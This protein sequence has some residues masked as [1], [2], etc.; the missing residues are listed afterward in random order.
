MIPPASRQTGFA[1]VSSIF[2]IVV[3]AALGVVMVTL[4][5][6]E[7]G[8]MTQSLTATRV[9]YGAKAGLEWGIHRAIA[10]NATCL[11]STSFPLTGPGFSGVSVT[12][13]CSSPRAGV[14]HI[15]SQASYGTYGSLEYSQRRI[16]AT[17]A[18]F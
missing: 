13:T 2:L 3:L 12:V 7:H 8:T 5:A 11:A 9:Y 18:N 16:E 15:T 10:V 1:I 6:V 17:M 14:F 4:S